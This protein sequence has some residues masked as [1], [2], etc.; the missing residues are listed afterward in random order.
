MLNNPQNDSIWLKKD[1]K[2][3]NKNNSNKMMSILHIDDSESF[4]EIIKIHFD[5]YYRTP[6]KFKIKSTLNTKTF[7]FRAFYQKYDLFLVDYRLNQI[8]DGLDLLK[9]V[10]D[11]GITTPFILLT[12]TDINSEI[13]NTLLNYEKTR[14]I[15]KNIDINEIFSEIIQHIRSLTHLL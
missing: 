13:Q 3:L 8:H 4:L 12:A 2:V 6:T 1:K 10:R 14:F 5:E 15:Q 11:K 9:K 7:L